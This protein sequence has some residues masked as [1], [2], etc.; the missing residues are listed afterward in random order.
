[1]RVHDFLLQYVDFVEEQDDGGFLE[2]LVVDDGLKQG[3]AFLHPIL[4]TRTRAHKLKH[5]ISHSGVLQSHPKA[6]GG[7]R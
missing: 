4:H 6:D 5:T 3:H 2:P 7:V 1:M